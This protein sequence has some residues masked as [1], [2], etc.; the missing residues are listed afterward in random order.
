M[1]NMERTVSRDWGLNIVRMN[2]HNLAMNLKTSFAV[3]FLSSLLALVGCQST[4]PKSEAPGAQNWPTLETEFPGQAGAWRVDP[5]ASSVR[6]YVFRDGAGAKFGHNHVLSVPRFEG[7]VLL[8]SDNA[9]QAHF[10]LRVPLT[11]LVVDDPALRATT[12][13][14]F[15]GERSASDIDGTRVNML[16]PKVLDAEKFPLMRLR[17]LRVEGDWPVLAAEVEITLHGVT[18]SQPVLLHVERDEKQLKARGE[19]VLRQSDYGI[20][21]FSALGGIMKVADAVAVS[22]EVTASKQ[23]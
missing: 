19:F 20:T 1:M 6:I 7:Y 5:A 10:D 23:R 8:P 22:F 17:S 21:P 12:G 9:R 16:G 13:G 2:D 4:A 3:V 14:G 18:R 11:E 15:S